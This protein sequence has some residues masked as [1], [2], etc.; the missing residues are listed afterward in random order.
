MTPLLEKARKL[1]SLMQRGGNVSFDE[2]ADL[3][4]DLTSCNIYVVG[5][6]GAVLGFAL[7]DGFECDVMRNLVLENMKFPAQYMGFVN[8][9]QETHSNISHEEHMCSFDETKPCKYGEK[10][11]TIIPIRGNRERLGT[12]ILARYDRDFN[13]DDLL[14]GEYSAAVIGIQLL[15]NREAAMEERIRKEAVI[16][17]AFTTLS[18]SEWEAIV[19]IL[20]ELKSNEGILIA[21]KV[22]DRLNI[23]RSVIVN[24]M[25][26]FQSAGLIETKSLGMKGTYIKIRNEY[27]L[28]EIKKHAKEGSPDLLLAGRV[29]PEQ[30][31]DTEFWNHRRRR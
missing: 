18:F 1:N 8:G 6:D 10:R 20:T 31:Y 22:A 28:D 13:D 27:L 2:V 19:G 29:Y 12:L 15:H 3:L 11:T 30:S 26:K 24:A 17:I 21:S 23:T 5:N 14:L 16:K 4:R 9:M 7:Q 25:R